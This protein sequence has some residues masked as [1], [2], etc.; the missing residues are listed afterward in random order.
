MST[1]TKL[2]VISI[3]LVLFLYMLI[4]NTSHAK[5]IYVPPQAKDLVSDADMLEMARLMSYAHSS[6]VLSYLE[7]LDEV[8]SPLLAD[9]RGVLGEGTPPLP[10]ISGLRADYTGQLDAIGQAATIAEAETLIGK[11]ESKARELEVTLRNMEGQLRALEPILREQAGVAEAE[12]R[13]RINSEVAKKTD[14]IRAE[15]N[16]IAQQRAAQAQAEA[17]AQVQAEAAAYGQCDKACMD[18]LRAKLDAQQAQFRVKLTTEMNAL[19]KE[20]EEELRVWAEARAEELKDKRVLEFERMQQEFE[21]IDGNVQAIATERQSFYYGSYYEKFLEKKAEIIRKA[22]DPQ[23]QAAIAKIQIHAPEFELAQREGRDVPT[24]EELLQLLQNGRDDLAQTIA[25][26]E[27]NEEIDEAVAGFKALWRDRQSEME[28][29][30]LKGSTDII[31]FTLKKLAEHDTEKKLTE[32]RIT[33]VDLIDELLELKRVKGE[34]S[35]E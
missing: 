25:E 26:A 28:L 8:L 2:G 21:A 12:I 23:I 17:E 16:Q 18:A 7:A 31:D 32:N 4:P 30:R 34:L 22:M 20:K 33:I 35:E 10:D 29:A 24:T 15:I 14:E 11:L 5:E 13:D 19:A 27:T 1:F 9:V 3:L 6:E